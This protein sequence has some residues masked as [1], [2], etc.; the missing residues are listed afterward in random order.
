VPRLKRT[1]TTVSRREPRLDPLQANSYMGLVSDDRSSFTTKVSA[2][3]WATGAEV[4]SLKRVYVAVGA[5]EHDGVRGD[6][7]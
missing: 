4:A 1:T 5:T 6:D 2:A 3:R 7:R